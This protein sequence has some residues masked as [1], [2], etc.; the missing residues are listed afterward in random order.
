MKI[1]QP[2]RERDFA[3]L[4]GGLTISLLGDG[5]YLVAVAWQVYDLSNRH[6]RSRWSA[7]HGRSGLRCSCL[8]GGVVSDRFDRRRVMISADLVRA[9]ALVIIGVLAATDTLE[10]WHLVALVLLYA[11]GEAFFGPALGAIIPNL[12]S[13][14]PDRRGQCV[15]ADGSPDLPA[16]PRARDRRHPRCLLGHGDAR[17]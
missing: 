3:L 8:T 17:F 4:W 14:D 13:R 7:W 15:G 11:A 6:R 1:L 16:V 9:V 5:I 12:V 2:L 10:I